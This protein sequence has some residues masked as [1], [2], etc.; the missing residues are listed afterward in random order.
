MNA[1]ADLPTVLVAPDSFKGTLTAAQ[2]AEAI[3]HG[4]SE[5]GLASDLCPIA[6]GGEGTLDALLVGGGRKRA[7]VSDPLGRPIQAEFG[8]RG[9]IAIV[10]TA[11]ASGLGLV[12][13]EDRDPIA[14]STFGTG[15]LIAAA[16]QAGANTVYLGVGG[17]ATTDGGTGAVTALKAAGGLRDARLIVLC[18]V[19]TPFEDAAHAFAEQKGAN[20]EQIEELSVRLQSLAGTY[21]KNPLG[22]AG[23]GAAGGLAGGLYAEFDAELVEGARFVLNAVGFDRRCRAAVAVVT[24]EGRLD[25]QSRA[26]KAVSHIAARARAVGRPCY[27]IVG[28][29]ELP[30]DRSTPMGLQRVLTA[31]TLDQISQAAR[32]VGEAV[33]EARLR[34]Q[35]AAQLD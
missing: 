3:K 34:H 19:R 18:D 12:A 28:S 4:L 21:A 24:G 25:E 13:P 7:V 23:S 35:P 11:S 20:R 5:C 15:E 22:V 29:C 16:I 14:A 2:V 9:D 10:E 6:D 26:G 32:N 8:L 33:V 30:E 17:S 31:S 27:A 1:S